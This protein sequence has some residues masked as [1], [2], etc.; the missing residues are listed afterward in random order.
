MLISVPLI[1]FVLIISSVVSI[2]KGNEV[3]PERGKEVIKT[4]YFYLVLF[5]TLMMTIGGTVAA[6]MAIADIVAPPAY[7]QSFEQY[8]SMFQNRGKSS[9][10]VSQAQTLSETELKTN[11]D[12]LV[13][14]QKAISK[15]RAV[16]S[17]VK[18]FGWII[19]PLPI[20]L[21][22]QRKMK[23]EPV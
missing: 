7:S 19:I 17:L 5:A 9:S 11:Y 2:K 14:S 4:I 18:S 20:F 16:N 12:Q 8:K 22:F 6:F 10:E 15:E 21:Y 23:I 13:A 1:L 3:F